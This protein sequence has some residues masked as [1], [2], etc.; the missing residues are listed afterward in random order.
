MDTMTSYPQRRRRRSKHQWSTTEQTRRALLDS[1]RNVFS[2]YG[3]ADANVAEIVEMANSSVG[4]LYHHFGGKSELFF[5]LWD[6]FRQEQAAT[7]DEAMRAAD[8]DD[9]WVRFLAG[10][11]QLLDSTWA[12]RDLVKLF[13]EGD[14]PPGF[15]EELSDYRR[16]AVSGRLAGRTSD[17]TAPDGGEPIDRMVSLVFASVLG[18]ARREIARAADEA[19]AQRIA[20]NVY[21]MVERL[22][23]IV[24]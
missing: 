12:Q 14:T 4:S 17:T 21:G 10:S 19:A 8:T 7:I 9:K 24:D 15:G 16:Q 20:D 18:E 5:A 22:R 11:R 6:Q 3:F 13:Y 1:A 23:P 2:Q